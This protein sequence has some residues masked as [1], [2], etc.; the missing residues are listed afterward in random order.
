MARRKEKKPAKGW[1]YKLRLPR[2]IAQRI[3]AKAKETGWP[4]NR[5]IIN[6]LAAY[7]RLERQ[8]DLGEHIG[9]LGNLIARYG[10]RIEWLD[11]SEQLLAAVDAVLKAQGGVQQAA[12]D[13]LRAVRSVM[14]K[15]E[16][17]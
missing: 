3:E 5:V 6:E 2:D 10:A 11:L 1:E 17:V 9:E 13:R 8:S 15:R 12:I 14:L 16:K 4:R 7:P